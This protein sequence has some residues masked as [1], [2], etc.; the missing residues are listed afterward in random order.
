MGEEDG[1]IEE[2]WDGRRGGECGLY[3][4][5]VMLNLKGGGGPFTAY[6]MPIGFRA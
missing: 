3:L 5:R 1:K 4:K 2:G 6:L